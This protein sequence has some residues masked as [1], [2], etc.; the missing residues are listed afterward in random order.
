MMKQNLSSI[1]RS[2][3]RSSVYH[4][5]AAASLSLLLVSCQLDPSPYEPDAGLMD[6]A[7]M[8]MAGES[9]T[10]GTSAGNTAGDV[11]GT[12]AGTSAG[13]SAGESAGDVAGEVAG[14]QAGASAGTMAGVSAGEEAAPERCSVQVSVTL[15]PSTPSGDTIYMASDVFEPQWLP[16]D[17]QGALIREDNLARGVIL[18]PNFT[19]VAY[20]FT[21]GNWET[22]EVNEDCTERA[23]RFSFIRCAA[24]EELTIEEEVTTWKGAGVC[25]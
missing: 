23:N 3:D 22:V 8:M 24:G 2:L 5:A 21:R 7:G 1:F 18:L 17:E 6:S 20:K 10:S 13:E 14:E 11:S 15:P 16:N 25:P 9:V 19:N 4:C 12:V